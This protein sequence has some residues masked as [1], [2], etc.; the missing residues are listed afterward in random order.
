MIA[1]S[2]EGHSNN[3]SRFSRSIYLPSSEKQLPCRF[4]GRKTWDSVYPCLTSN[5]HCRNGKKKVYKRR[6]TGNSSVRF[7]WTKLGWFVFFFLSTFGFSF[8]APCTINRNDKWVEKWKKNVEN[9]QRHQTNLYN[10]S[11]NRGVTV[12]NSK[13][14]TLMNAADRQHTKVAQFCHPLGVVPWTRGGFWLMKNICMPLVSLFP[15]ANSSFCKPCGRLQRKGFALSGVLFLSFFL[16]LVSFS[17]SIGFTFSFVI[18]LPILFFL[19]PFSSSFRHTILLLKKRP[20]NIRSFCLP[21]LSHS[22]RGIVF[23][24][25]C[26][27]LL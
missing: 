19:H 15:I 3:G 7:K 17:L 8:D 20:Q 10:W 27:C 9:F 18:F 23:F 12:N 4:N 5:L 13:Q 6:K 22:D 11:S 16:S 1:S 2:S 26:C 21:L 14:T 25:V 24:L